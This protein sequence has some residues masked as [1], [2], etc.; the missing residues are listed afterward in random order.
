MAPARATVRLTTREMAAMETCRN[1][2]G[3]ETKTSWIIAELRVCFADPRTRKTP[4]PPVTGRSITP[5]VALLLM[6]Y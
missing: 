4:I 3:R 5:D 1:N 6:Q 2:K